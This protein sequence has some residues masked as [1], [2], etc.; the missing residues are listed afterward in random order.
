MSTISGLGAP[1]FV[2]SGNTTGSDTGS[3]DQNSGGTAS[4]D[5]P[6]VSAQT[7]PTETAIAP[8]TQNIVL[9]QIEPSSSAQSEAAARQIAEAAQQ[10]YKQQSILDTLTSASTKVAN[11]T[12]LQPQEPLQPDS[13]AEANGSPV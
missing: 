3:S 6:A 12:T 11:L 8:S 1:V 4:S 10:A 7:S 9:A 5:T 2:P 13:S